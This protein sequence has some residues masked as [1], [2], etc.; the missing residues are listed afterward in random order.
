MPAVFSEAQFSP[1]LADTLAHEAGITRV[2]TTLY[3]DTVGP[4]PN[5]TYLAMMS[6]NMDQIVEA[7]G[8]TGTGPAIADPPARRHR[9]LRR[10]RR[11]WPTS[12]STIATG[13]LLAVIG[14]NGAGK[15][16]LLKTIA[17]LLTPFSGTVEVFGGPAAGRGASGSPTSRRRSSSTGRSRSPSATS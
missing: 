4:P 17:G 14:P 6:W 11:A 5:D 9:R 13:S 7:L 3:N 10:P 16:T 12:I 8:M 2:V 15:S 1:E